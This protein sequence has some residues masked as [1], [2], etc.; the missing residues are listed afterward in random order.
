MDATGS[1]CSKIQRSDGDSCVIFLTQLVSYIGNEIVPLAQA[2]SE[3]NDAHFY[4]YFLGEWFKYAHIPRVVATDMG[5]AIQSA[6]ST[7]CNGVSF[8]LYNDIC[9][10][11]L[12]KQE[13]FIELKTHL[14]TDIAHIKHAISKWKCWSKSG[15]KTKLLFTR[16][17]GLMTIVKRLEDF[18]KLFED[19]LIITLSKEVNDECERA[20]KEFNR[21]VCRIQV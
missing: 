11:I 20:T 17:I 1:V 9:L 16:S 21:K 2:L 3:K 7:S 8:S 18:E 6:L 12:L 13:C 14:R 10:R 15:G 19:L 5:K 4:N